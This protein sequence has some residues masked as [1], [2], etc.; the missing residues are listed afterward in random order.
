[1]DVEENVDFNVSHHG[2]WVVI[3][4]CSNGT[5]GVD[6]TRNELPQ[7]SVDTFI[8]CFADQVRFTLFGRLHIVPLNTN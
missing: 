2:E 8:D 7:E 4:L 1:M 6:V 3:G 5:I